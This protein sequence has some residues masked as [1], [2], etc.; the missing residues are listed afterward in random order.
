LFSLLSKIGVTSFPKLIGNFL[1]ASILKLGISSCAFL[2]IHSILSPPSITNLNSLSAGLYKRP[3]VNDAPA[4][5]FGYFLFISQD[6]YDFGFA[7][8]TP[9]DIASSIADFET[10]L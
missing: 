5:C 8:T 7:L 1:L 10:S 2:R 3:F 4:Q 9:E 6:K